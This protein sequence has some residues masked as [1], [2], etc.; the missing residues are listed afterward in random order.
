MTPAELN[1]LCQSPGMEGAL[2]R[3]VRSWDPDRIAAWLEQEKR[4]GLP[5]EAA[6][7]CVAEVMAGAAFVLAQHLQGD[8]KGAI[9]GE[10]GLMGLLRA[11]V[12]HKLEQVGGKHIIVPRNYPPTGG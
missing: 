9:L 1:R 12:A 6:V 3:L 7:G 8:K 11:S 10:R 4:N 2:W 5:P